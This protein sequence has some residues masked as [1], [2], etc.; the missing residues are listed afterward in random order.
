MSELFTNDTFIEI[1]KAVLPVIITGIIT[2]LITK[3]SYHKNIPLDKLE[4]AYNRI[5]YPIYCLI[6]SDLEIPQ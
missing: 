2:F 5:Y 4:I 3:Y 1:L 6:T